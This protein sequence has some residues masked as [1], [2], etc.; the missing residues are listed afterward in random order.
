MGMGMATGKD[1][2]AEA[3]RQAIASPLLESSFQ[4]ASGLIVNIRAA[5]A[6][7][8]LHEMDEAMAV[9]RA[10]SHPEAH[11]KVGLIWDETLGGAVQVTVIATGFKGRQEGVGYRTAY[12][13]APL[14]TTQGASTASS[15]V[16]E[17]S[18][19][20]AQLPAFLRTHAPSSAR[21][22]S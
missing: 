14:H 19:G 10:E 15:S 7:F 17:D 20:G 22:R 18:D 2:A 8:K 6:D 16:A 21:P 9:I 12:A 4:G 5:Q 11:T 1:R 13:A 3:A